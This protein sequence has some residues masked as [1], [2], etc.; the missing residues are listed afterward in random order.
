[1]SEAQ[2]RRQYI[3]EMI[4]RYD[5]YT[6]DDIVYQLKKEYNMDVSRSSVSRDLKE[7]KAHRDKKTGAIT[8]SETA[9]IKK[10]E[11][12]LIEIL[13]VVTTEIEDNLETFMIITTPELVQVTAY[14]LENVFSKDF[15][16]FSAL[17]TPFGKIICYYPSKYK[18]KFTEAFNELV[19]LKES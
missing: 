10:N 12:D 9:Q 17:P 7:I 6:Q 18:N 2:L 1:M 14:H 19:N 3:R 15:H 4:G 16:P 11:Q 8:L 5:V 13:N